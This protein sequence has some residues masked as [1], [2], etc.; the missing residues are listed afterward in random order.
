MM[1][2]INYWKANSKWVVILSVLT[3]HKP[4][5]STLKCFSSFPAS[6]VTDARNVPLCSI[7]TL[8][9]ARVDSFPV[10]VTQSCNMLLFCFWFSWVNVHIIWNKG[11]EE[12][13]YLL[14]LVS[15]VK[16]GDSVLC[17]PEGL[18]FVPQAGQAMWYG[19]W[20]LFL[21]THWPDDMSNCLVCH[22]KP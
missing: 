4:F 9:I 17:W 10:F 22:F 20:G 6:L 19:V 18:V 13:S 2:N 5:T 11:S 14:V 16:T 3:I 15:L 7:P 12:K 1:I 8:C 21:I